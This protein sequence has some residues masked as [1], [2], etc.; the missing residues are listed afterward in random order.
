M[1]R[2]STETSINKKL[3]ARECDMCFRFIIP[4]HNYANV[5]PHNG[6]E[7]FNY[8]LLVIEGRVELYCSTDVWSIIIL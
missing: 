6:E 5:Y 2:G 1:H 8:E 4:L 7:A 3:E